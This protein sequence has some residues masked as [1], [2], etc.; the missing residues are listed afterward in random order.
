MNTDRF[1]VPQNPDR[2]ELDGSLCSG[3][4]GVPRLA[5]RAWGCDPA[6]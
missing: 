1:D 3:G 5:E 4:E 6:G 2:V